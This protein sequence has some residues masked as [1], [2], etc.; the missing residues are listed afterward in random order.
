LFT[1]SSDNYETPLMQIFG[2]LEGNEILSRIFI[3]LAPETFVQR[4]L[5]S[6]LTTLAWPRVKPGAEL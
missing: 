4:M 3:E 2:L 6:P 1:N 5:V